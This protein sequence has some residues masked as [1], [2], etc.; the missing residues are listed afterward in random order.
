MRNRGKDKNA[1][2]ANDIQ[3]IGEIKRLLLESLGKKEMTPEEI[4]RLMEDNNKSVKI[5]LDK[6]EAIENPYK[7]ISNADMNNPKLGFKPEDR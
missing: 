7:Y 6:L 3:E 4:F 2:K 5:A 1:L